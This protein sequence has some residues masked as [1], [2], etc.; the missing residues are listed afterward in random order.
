MRF[1]QTNPVLPLELENPQKIANLETSVIQKSLIVESPGIK[2]ANASVTSLNSR[3][4]FDII[5]IK[6]LLYLFHR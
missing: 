2:T 6:E 5:D 3:R 1:L 4:T